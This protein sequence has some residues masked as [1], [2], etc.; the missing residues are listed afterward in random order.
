LPPELGKINALVYIE[1]LRLLD[2]FKDLPAKVDLV[3]KVALV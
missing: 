1:K 2:L 3:E